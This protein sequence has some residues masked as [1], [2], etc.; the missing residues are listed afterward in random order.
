MKCK[1]CGYIYDPSVGDKRYFVKPNTPFEFLP[2]NWR[3][4]ICKY[5]KSAFYE[6]KDWTEKI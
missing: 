2:E 5:P 4:P 3:C 6:I 1:I